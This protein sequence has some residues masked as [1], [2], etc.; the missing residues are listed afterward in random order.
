MSA[1]RNEATVRTW[2]EEAWNRGNVEGQRA[3]FSPAYAW[4]EL[5]EVFGKGAE[6]LLQ[7]VLTFRAGFPDLRF[8]IEDVV[9]AG[10]MVVWRATG[11]GTHRAEFMGIPAT[12]RSI[13]VQAI[14]MSRFENGLWREDHVCWDQF[15]M[16]QQLGVIPP[17][18]AAAV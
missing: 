15:G 5:P 12:S 2:V 13:N 11:T 18:D 17:V 7:F 10:D 4:P 6:A 16:L 8:E 14:I 3:I 9:A 1:E